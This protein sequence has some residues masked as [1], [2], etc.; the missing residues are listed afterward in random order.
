ME[1]I[2]EN[3]QDKVNFTE[4]MKDL[5]DKAIEKS[6]YL[7]G[8][9]IDSEISVLLVDDERIREINREQRNIDKP[10]D[11]LSFPIVNIVEGKINPGIGDYDMEN[12]LILLGDIVISLET[13]VKQAEEY[14]HS[15]ERELAFLVTHGV[16]HLL[17]YD[18]QDREQEKRMMSKQESVLKSLGLSRE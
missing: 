1:V 10:T 2:I 15:L 12:G 16:F 13:A 4:K 5:I 14:G 3:I 9:K 11:V 6:L 7:E 8:F 17:G 18:H